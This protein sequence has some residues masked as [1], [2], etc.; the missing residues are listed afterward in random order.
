MRARKRPFPSADD[1]TQLFS[2]ANRPL[3]IFRDLGIRLDGFDLVREIEFR[4]WLPFRDGRDIREWEGTALVE[5][6]D[7]RLVAIRA[8]PRNQEARLPALYDRW[9]RSWKISLGIFA[10]PLFL[11]IKTFRTA[12]RPLAFH[13][14][15][16]FDH[17]EGDIRLPTLLRYETH[18]AV[19]RFRTELRVVSTRLYTDYRDRSSRI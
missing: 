11:P 10:G 18:R 9:A 16:R 8:R 4:G 19:S 5:A 7:L 17:L 12:R 15:V 13:C 2:V 3:I 14:V 1:W 6:V